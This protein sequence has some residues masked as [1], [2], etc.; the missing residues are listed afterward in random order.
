MTTLR[1]TGL[2]LL[3]FPERK[4]A[5]NAGFNIQYLETQW[6]SYLALLTLI[7]KLPNSMVIYIL[8]FQREI[9]RAKAICCL[10]SSWKSH[11]YKLAQTF[12]VTYYPLDCFF[13]FFHWLF[14]P[15]SI[16]QRHFLCLFAGS[17]WLYLRQR[18]CSRLFMQR[19]VTLSVAKD[20][21]RNATGFFSHF[22]WPARLSLCGR[23][24]FWMFISWGPLGPSE[25]GA[26]AR[27]K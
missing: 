11:T 17:I 10:T 23:T 18:H 25:A 6:K 4:N 15:F 16:S 9:T 12:K 20:L 22:F 8:F 5:Y 3:F 26:R 24:S 7:L 27:T 2:F 21:S 19:N 13:P 1:Q 14:F